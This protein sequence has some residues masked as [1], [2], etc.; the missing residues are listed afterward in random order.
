[1]FTIYSPRSSHRKKKT[2][3][4]E[5]FLYQIIISFSQSSRV[6]VGVYLSQCEETA[7]N[8]EPKT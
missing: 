5:I 2:K 6:K 3:K 7:F 1:M 4:N 8:L